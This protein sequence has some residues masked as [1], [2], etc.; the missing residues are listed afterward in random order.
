MIVIYN[1]FKGTSPNTPYDPNANK[2]LSIML[3]YL[4][5]TPETSILFE[6]NIP[7]KYRKGPSFYIMINLCIKWAQGVELKE[8]LAKDYYKEDEDK[9]DETID[10][11]QATISFKIPHLL[12]PIFDIKNPKSIFISCMR[13]GAT[14]TTARTMIEMGIARET[15]L[16][17]YN[18]Y[19]KSIS[20]S[21]NTTT[22]YEKAIRDT[23]KNIYSI[24]PYWIQIQLD[25]LL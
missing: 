9:I 18:H 10:L 24:L 7:R 22:D 17:L 3:S 14:S 12:K 13:T 25:Y 6:K 8:L 20:L 2:Q 5:D 11:L 1:N 4:R 23:L 19:F 21:G 15:A 16:Y